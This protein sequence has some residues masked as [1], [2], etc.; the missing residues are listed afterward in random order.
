V[1]NLDGASVAYRFILEIGP[2]ND[3]RAFHVGIDTHLEW[4][5]SA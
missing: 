1:A 2:E 4:V 3:K 5:I